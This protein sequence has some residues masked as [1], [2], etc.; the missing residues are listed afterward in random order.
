ME[1]KSTRNGFGDGVVE[2]GKEDNDV[3]V[4]SADVCESTRASYFAERFPERFFN[5]GVAEQN[6]IGVGGGLALVGKT[7]FVSTYGV[8]AT[9]RGLDQIR[10]T[11]CFSNLNVKIIGTHGGLLVGPDGATHHA[12][13]EITLMRAMPNMRVIVPCDSI[14]AKKATLIAG[15]IKGPFYLRLGR[16]PVPVITDENTPFTLGKCGELHSGDDVTIIACGVMVYLSLE[17]IKHLEKDGI[18]ARLLNL[19]TIKPLDKE[20]ILKAAKETNAIVTAEEHLLA[21]G[22][23]SAV[24]ELLVKNHPVPIEMVGIDDKFGESGKPW[25]VMEGFGLTSTAIYEAVKRVLKRKKSN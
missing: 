2:L 22:M 24:S 20:T 5:V 7:V 4:L 3:V 9:C 10:T 23:G 17:A 1:C 19:H 8:F 11:V 16:E 21:G 13:E 18:S 6:L 15:R 25:E 14:E 12:L